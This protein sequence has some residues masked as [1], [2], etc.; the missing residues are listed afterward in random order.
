MFAKIGGSSTA[1]ANFMQCF[2]DDATIQDLPAEPSLTA[3]IESFRV[4][5]LGG[6]TAFNHESLAAMAGFTSDVLVTGMPTP[7]DAEVEA[8]K[9]RF[10][11]VLVGTH[12]L[13]KDQPAQ[14]WVFAEKM[15]DMVDALTQNGVV[16]ILTTI[17]QRTD[18]PAKDM[19]VPRYN[20]V[21][22]AVA[23]GRQI[24][25]VDL[26]LA[27]SKLPMAGL[28]DNGELSVFVSALVDRPCFF[29]ETALM[30]GY[31]VRNL[32]ALRALDRARQVVVEVVPELDAPGS[33]LEGA[34]TMTDPIRIP[35]L[36]F[37]DLRSTADSTSDMIDNYLGACDE[38]K[39]ESGPEVFYKLEVTAPIDVRIMVFDRAN[40]DV[41]VHVL[42]KLAAENCLKRNDREIT[43]PLPIGTYYIAVD[44]FAGDVPD[45]AAG[46]YA[47]VVMED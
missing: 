45:G 47:I 12:D 20:A 41:D 13:E 6:V 14:L 36:P 40:V 39:D 5:D 42:S 10:A 28:V 9:P 3:T 37:V 21:L 7:V 35:S 17:P 2:G 43:G 30:Y 44:S 31:N 18:L 8:I 29:S 34:G 15:L 1:S 19:F 11:Q 46:E 22:R 26:N 33:R 32:E 23:Q 4:V 25:L 16:P 24:P 27:L 38:T